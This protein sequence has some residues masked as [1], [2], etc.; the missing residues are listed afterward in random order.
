MEEGKTPFRPD[1]RM[2]KVNLAIGRMILA[3]NILYIGCTRTGASSCERLLERRPLL[4]A[5]DASNQ[6]AIQTIDSWT[7]RDLR[8]LEEKYTT[9]KNRKNSIMDNMV[10]IIEKYTEKLENEIKER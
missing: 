3:E 10:H 6:E 1:L 8:F 4:P 7:V 2:L 5:N 9:A